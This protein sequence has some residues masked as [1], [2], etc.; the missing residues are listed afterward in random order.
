[1]KRILS[2]I[3]VFCIVAGLTGCPAAPISREAPKRSLEPNQSNNE[4]ESRLVQVGSAVRVDHVYVVVLKDKDTGHE[5]LVCYSNHG[6]AI[7]SLK[8]KEDK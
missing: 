8:G 6:V 3:F 2:I 5:Y 1:M 4:P 7:S